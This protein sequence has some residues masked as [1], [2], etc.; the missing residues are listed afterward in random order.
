[1]PKKYRHISLIIHDLTIWRTSGP[2]SPKFRRNDKVDVEISF[3][4]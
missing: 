1:M 3:I 2:F 4:T